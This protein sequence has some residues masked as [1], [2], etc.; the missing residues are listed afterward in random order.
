MFAPLRVTLPLS[1]LVRAEPLMPPLRVSRSLKPWRMTPPAAPESTIGLATTIP[2]LWLAQALLE[3]GLNKDDS[4][5][6]LLSVITLVTS[7]SAVLFPT[8]RTPVFPDVEPVPFTVIA[9]LNVPGLFSEKFDE[10]PPAV[11]LNTKF[12]FPVVGVVI[13]PP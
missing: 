6:P 3:T 13:V 2:E 4:P 5:P 8:P 1:V 11:A 9:P 7:P 12:T 10:S